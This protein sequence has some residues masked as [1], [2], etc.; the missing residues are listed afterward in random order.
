MLK[1][2]INNYQNVHE[3]PIGVGARSQFS[4]V[5]LAPGNVISD[6]K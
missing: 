3:G 4:E 1:Y 2:D 5:A 6:G